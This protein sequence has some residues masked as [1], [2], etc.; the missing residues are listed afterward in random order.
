MLYNSTTDKLWGKKMD[1]GKSLAILLAKKGV[2]KKD[3]AD[4][5]GVDPN[6]VSRMIKFK[7]WGGANL[8][9]TAEFFGVSVSEFIREGEL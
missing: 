5:I 9:K 1:A 2:M 7:V 6:T 4:A 3:F 8:E